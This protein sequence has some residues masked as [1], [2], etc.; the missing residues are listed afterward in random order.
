MLSVSAQRFY[1]VMSLMRRRLD[2]NYYLSQVITVTT[3]ALNEIVSRDQRTVAK[4]IT[5]TS[6]VCNIATSLMAP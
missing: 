1:I 2:F 3:K 5:I 4:D 6:T